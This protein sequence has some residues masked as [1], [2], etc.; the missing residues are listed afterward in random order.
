MKITTMDLETLE[1]V[2]V[3][4]FNTLR[5]ETEDGS[6]FEVYING[7]HLQVR[8][9]DGRLVVLPDC[10]NGIQLRRERI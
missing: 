6:V 8:T 10:G 1:W 7:P 2:P 4:N 9:P 5:F 3:E